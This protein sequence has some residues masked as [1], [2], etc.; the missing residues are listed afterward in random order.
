MQQAKKLAAD[1]RAPLVREIKLVIA[2]HQK[3]RHN[4]T[5]KQKKRREAETRVRAGRFS[6][7]L[8]AVWIA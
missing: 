3:E 6:R 2:Q 1:G 5:E 8:R 4:L 7:G